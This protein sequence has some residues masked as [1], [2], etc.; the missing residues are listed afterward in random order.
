[1]QIGVIGLGKMGSGLVSRLIANN[2]EVVTYDSDPSAI[3]KLN[4]QNIIPSKDLN[5]FIE[6]LKNISIT[7]NIIIWVMIP[8]GKPTEDTLNILRD[9]TSEGDIIIDGGNS[10]YKDT[11]R[12]SEMF[13]SYNV[14]FLDA[15]TSGGIWGPKTG[16][17]LMIGG[18]KEIYDKVEPI[19]KSLSSKNTKV[20]TF[21]VGPSGSG[22]FLK[23][24]HNGIEYGMMQSLAEGFELLKAKE[25]FNYNLPL[26][27]ELWQHGSVIRSWL[28]DLSK[29]ALDKDSDLKSL[30]P[31][32][33]DSGEGRWTIKEAI[34]LGVPVPAITASIYTR[35]SSRNRNSFGLKILAALRQQFGGH[36][37]KKQ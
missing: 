8:S 3:S 9:I 12:R 24:V 18:D 22:H 10:Y 26:V 23:M 33:E 32:V 16:Y 17:C 29:I 30:S 2:H 14:N 11:L 37:V 25:E 15:G 7:D 35:F 19:F 28:L 5:D 6:K 31:Y 4:Q 13:K 36:S 34:N 1:M 27:A 21:L 20:E